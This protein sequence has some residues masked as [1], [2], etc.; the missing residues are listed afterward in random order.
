ME[1]TCSLT[2][3]ADCVA[4]RTVMTS[5]MKEGIERLKREIPI[6]ALIGES[7]PL[8]RVGTNLRGRCPFHSDENPSLIV[9]PARG[10]KPGLW[11][12]PVCDSGGDIFSWVQK[13]QN[14]TFRDALKWL[15]SRRGHHGVSVSSRLHDTT[16]TANPLVFGPTHAKWLGVYVKDSRRQLERHPKAQEYFWARRIRKHETLDL[17]DAG[18]VPGDFVARLP[19]A[20]TS[21]GL[22]ARTALR[23]LK[24]LG[25][26]DTELF[27]GCVVVP[28]LGPDFRPVSLLG[29]R[30][31]AQ[32]RSFRHWAIGY[33]GIVNRR[34]LH[35]YDS[36][37]LCEGFLDSMSWV[38]SGVLQS[39]CTGGVSGFTSELLDE[40]V[41][42][43]KR[44]FLGMDSDS[45][46]DAG[47][48]AIA[49]KILVRKPSMEIVRIR[50]S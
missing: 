14:L 11:R 32:S 10:D 36:I 1:S 6:E 13:S 50:Y 38:E 43:T 9:T 39:V 4:A 37:L 44:V 18:F 42:N 12:C 33:R 5:A 16:D 8:K 28:M 48:I 19:A 31:A 45:A 26:N 22:E 40:L 24:V 21:D 2:H 20:S 27:A 15:A 34:A 46:G 3:F 29:R 7:V 47:S 30:I 49:T 25:P 41:K 35:L 17:F 23:Q